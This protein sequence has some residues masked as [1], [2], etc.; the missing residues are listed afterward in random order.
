MNILVTGVNGQLG[1][2]MRIL[3]SHHAELVSASDKR[4]K[5]ER[6]TNRNRRPSHHRT[7]GVR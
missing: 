3:D 7:E 4:N 1:N 5:N 2:E 6:Y